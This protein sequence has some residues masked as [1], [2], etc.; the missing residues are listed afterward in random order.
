MRY[1]DIRGAI[2]SLTS[3]MLDNP[4]EDIYPTTRFY[5]SV[6]KYIESLLAAQREEIAEEVRAM[7]RIWK[8]TH[9]P[10]CTCQTCGDSND[11]ECQCPRNTI[12]DEVALKLS[13]S[14][15]EQKNQNCEY[16]KYGEYH[17]P[18]GIYPCNNVQEQ[19]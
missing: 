10:C 15:P 2:C 13:P 14:T 3:R 5:D 19:K 11:N 18:N 17:D 4:Q 9:G 1:G 8:P 12:L 16:C 6:E 7:K